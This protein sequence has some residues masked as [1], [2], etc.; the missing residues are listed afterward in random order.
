MTL[1]DKLGARKTEQLE[2]QCNLSRRE[3]FARQDELQGWRDQLIGELEG[4]L[5]QQVSLH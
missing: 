5:R 4:Q 2:T 1:S 3:L